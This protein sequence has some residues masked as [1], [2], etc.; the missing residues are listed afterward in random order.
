MNFKFVLPSININF[1][2]QTEFEVNQTKIGS[3][4]QKSTMIS[5]C[6]IHIYVS[7]KFMEKFMEKCRR[8]RLFGE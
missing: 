6:K 8:S 4:N 2:V 5:M 3:L 7:E 1:D